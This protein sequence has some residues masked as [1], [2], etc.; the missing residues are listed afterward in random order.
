MICFEVTGCGGLFLHAGV[1]FSWH[2]PVLSLLSWSAPC[3]N[4]APT[5]ALTALGCAP[6]WHLPHFAAFWH[7]G[8]TSVGDRGLCVE[9]VSGPGGGRGGSRIHRER[10][11]SHA[12]LAESGPVQYLPGQPSQGRRVQVLTPLL[13]YS[14]QSWA[15]A[16][17][18]GVVW[19]MVLQVLAGGTIRGIPLAATEGCS[20]YCYYSNAIIRKGIFFYNTQTIPFLLKGRK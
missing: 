8:G 12:D 18:E 3:W 9:A 17:W 7:Q 10:L 19:A 4:S 14:A 11:T 13:P 16:A 15:R 1:Q 5:A 6:L 20:L 2:K